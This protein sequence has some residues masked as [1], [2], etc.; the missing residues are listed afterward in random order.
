MPTEDIIGY[1]AQRKQEFG[2]D[3]LQDFLEQALVIATDLH[4]AGVE[5]FILHP[6]PERW[7]GA[8]WSLVFRKHSMETWDAMIHAASATAMVDQAI[9]QI[10][11]E[12]AKPRRRKPCPND[13]PCLCHDM[14]GG[15]MHP[16]QP[17]PGKEA[18]RE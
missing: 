14:T 9:R 11:E 16:G 4:L 15:P 8:E 2:I 13:C 18:G 10:N 6:E 5:C 12:S 17:C 7:V 1:L 3:P